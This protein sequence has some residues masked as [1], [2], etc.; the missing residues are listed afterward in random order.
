MHRARN[1]AMLQPI[2]G[3]ALAVKTRGWPGLTRIVSPRLRRRWPVVPT[4]AR[5]APPRRACRGKSGPATRPE[6]PTAAAPPPAGWGA[7]PL[8]APR[9]DGTERVA[10]PRPGD[11]P[12]SRPQGGPSRTRPARA[13]DA[14]T[15]RVA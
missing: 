2:I 14:G 11:G 5:G 1:Q 13:A 9:S 8:G 3:V 7:G 10:R 4:P 15:T 12:A 6:P